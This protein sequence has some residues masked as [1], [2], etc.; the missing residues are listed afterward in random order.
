MILDLNMWKNQIF[1]DPYTFGQYTDTNGYIYTVE[2]TTWVKYANK[3]T[4]SYEWRWNNINPMTNR[5]F[6]EDDKRMNSKYFNYSLALKGMAFIPSV[7]AF[8]IFG[9]LIL[10]Y[11]REKS[12]TVVSSRDKV[13]GIIIDEWDDENNSKSGMS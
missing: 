6:G 4:L 7:S 9:V 8:I 2:N 11:G 5:T 1:Y 12:V 10:L 3:T 13:D